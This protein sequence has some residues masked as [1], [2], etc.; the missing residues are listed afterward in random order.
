MKTTRPIK[1][2]EES[3]L[4]CAL[5]VRSEILQNAQD[6]V[7]PGC[8][9]VRCPSERTNSATSWTR[10]ARLFEALLRLAH[11]VLKAKLLSMKL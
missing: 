7:L 5:L 1:L 8:C 9:S 10:K 4:K 11:A 6:A 2:V 3:F